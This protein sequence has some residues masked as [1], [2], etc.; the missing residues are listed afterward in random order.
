MFTPEYLNELKL[1]VSHL[2]EI[3]S[4]INLLLDLICI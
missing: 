4:E 2:I 1:A 3:S